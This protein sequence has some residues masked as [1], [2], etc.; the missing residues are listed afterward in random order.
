MPLEAGLTTTER[1]FKVVGTR[2]VRPDGIDK[3]TGRARFGAD[4][5]APGMLIG[6]ILRSPHPHARIRKIDTSKAEA[7][8]GVK[9]VVTRDDFK[10]DGVADRDVWRNVMARDKALYEG[11]AVAAV[12][13]I[14]SAVARKA[15]KLIKVDYQVLPHVTDVDEALKPGAPLLHDDLFTTGVEPKPKKPSNL[16]RRLEFGHGDVEKGFKEA[17]IVI[18]RRFKTEATHQ[19]Y[20]EPHACL[21][22]VGPD[23]QGDLWVCTQ[24]HYM[25]RNVC[26]NLLQMDVSKLR[27][28]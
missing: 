15:L 1:K 27:V 22:S 10:E 2:P 20:I 3:V 19:G 12:A 18:E 23:G 28:E 26:A 8:A 16:A 6:R 4:A 25:I 14:N 17:D 11:H 5:T 7:L 13:A 24:G 21:A 9:A